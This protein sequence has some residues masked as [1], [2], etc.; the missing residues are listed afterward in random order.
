[1][2]KVLMT[3]LVAAA[4][5]AAAL[6][7]VA[8]SLSGPVRWTPD[9]L[10]YQAR[11]YELE[12][13][14]RNAALTRAFEGPLGARLR[15]VDRERSGDPDWVRYNARF[16]ERRLAVPVAARALEPVAGTRAILD[17]SLLGYLA[18]VLAVFG[19]LLLRFRLAVAAGVALATAF[20]PALT[21]HSAYPLTDSWGVALETAG[22]ACGLLALERGRWWL[23]PWACA[24]FLLAF[25]RDTIWVLVGG[26][27]W[28]T[29]NQRSRSKEG[30]LMVAS[31]L[32]PAV[33]AVLLVPVPL[34]ELLGE[35]LNGLQPNPDATWGSIA[36]SYPAALEELVRANGGFVR[37][38]AWY[39][40]AFLGCGLIALFALGRGPRAGA[41]TTFLKGAALAGGAYVLVVPVFSAFRLELVWVPLA[42]FGLG[43][44]A[45]GVAGRVRRPALLRLAA[46]AAEGPGL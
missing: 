6:L 9:G 16:Y 22:L 24:V 11:V 33:L 31:G 4:L 34:R 19:L 28:L 45:D 14:D 17:V 21:S 38:G 30:G 2:R 44:V 29:L 25:T 23:A 8:D 39:S 1:V 43:F 40:A 13:M 12:G 42:A 20:L 3:I 7:A 41:E 46:P 5:S 37:D 27:V 10:F 26:A 32:V 36:G 35:M 15:A 18:A